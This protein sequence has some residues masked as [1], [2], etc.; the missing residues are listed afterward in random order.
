MDRALEE[1]DFWISFEI[2][3]GKYKQVKKYERSKR[4]VE[5]FR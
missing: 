3:W 2:Y 1:E 5:N 4:D